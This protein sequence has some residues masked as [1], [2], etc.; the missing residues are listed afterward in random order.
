MIIEIPPHPE[1]LYVHVFEPIKWLVSDRIPPS[2]GVFFPAQPELEVYESK[3]FMSAKSK[4]P[5][6][7]G[8]I[9]DVKW[10]TIKWDF[11]VLEMQNL[12]RD[13]YFRGKTLRLEVE[14]FRARGLNLIRLKK[15]W[16]CL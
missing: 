6:P 2:Y 10:P 14:P 7:V 4:S 5:P 3:G 13:N 9:G 16:V 1:H 15:V 12:P 11:D 8:Y